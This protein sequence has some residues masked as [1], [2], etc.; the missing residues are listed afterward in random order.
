LNKSDT[1]S[2]RVDR[3][4]GRLRAMSTSVFKSRVT[5]QREYHSLEPAT[6]FRNSSSHS[7]YGYLESRISSRNTSHVRSRRKAH[8]PI[9]HF[10][11]IEPEPLEI[12]LPPSS[13]PNFIRKGSSDSMCSFNGNFDGQWERYLELKKLHDARVNAY[14]GVFF[15]RWKI[16]FSDSRLGRILHQNRP[17]RRPRSE[18]ATEELI[19]E[20]R[21]TAESLSRSSVRHRTLTADECVITDEISVPAI[22]RQRPQTSVLLPKAP[23]SGPIHRPSDSEDVTERHS[24]SSDSGSPPP[25]RY[26]Q[27]SSFIEER[28]G[29][30]DSF[31]AA[32]SRHPPS[33]RL[34][35]A[36][37][38]PL[39]ATEGFSVAMA[40]PPR[41][42]RLSRSAT[43]SMD[44]NAAAPM[45][46]SRKAVD[47]ESD[48]S[49]LDFN[50]VDSSD[51]VL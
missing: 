34:G 45:Q 24:S 32:P 22:P 31:R 39:R 28:T 46:E 48:S 38:P 50:I 23:L 19:Q 30:A 5:K 13:R 20:A 47:T 10:H 15:R 44:V 43:F 27:S 41:A 37:R 12:E 2:S 21:A 40:P 8:S 36:P 51:A 26:F 49:G 14:L 16:T 17:L 18:L 4:N 3:P 9:K 35:A 29:L 11:A 42:A 25:A 7:R 6:H 1:F 33:V